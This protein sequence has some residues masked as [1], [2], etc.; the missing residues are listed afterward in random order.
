MN[1][2]SL[3]IAIAIIV[4]IFL[5]M[6]FVMKALKIAAA[7]AIIA[8][9]LGV[10]FYGFSGFFDKVSD[11]KDQIPELGIQ[12]IAR[13]VTGCT[14]DQDCAY[15]LSPGDCRTIEGYC[16]NVIKEENYQKVFEEEVLEENCNRTSIE[17]D[18]LIECECKLHKEREGK[19]KQWLGKKVEEKAGYTYCWKKADSLK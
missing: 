14:T 5:I 8:I 1:L 13:S 7:L 16:N 11:V 3:I 17:F 19:I 2:T 9:V 18:P 10:W 6:H 15:I 4:V 12:K